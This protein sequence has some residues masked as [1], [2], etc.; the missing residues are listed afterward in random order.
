MSNE[1]LKKLGDAKILGSKF[2]GGNSGCDNICDDFCDD[3]PEGAPMQLRPYVEN[4]EPEYKA[5]Q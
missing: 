3:C 4:P 1:L 2:I 5:S